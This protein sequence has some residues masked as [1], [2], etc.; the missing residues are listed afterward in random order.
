LFDL[1]TLPKGVVNTSAGIGDGILAI[2]S[3][4]L[5]RGQRLRNSLDIGSVNS[6]SAECGA[7]RVTG[8]A[9]ALAAYAGGAIPKV[10]IH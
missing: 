8:T 4:G 2:L 5:V 10:L 6:C 3:F 1:P 7:G 9:L